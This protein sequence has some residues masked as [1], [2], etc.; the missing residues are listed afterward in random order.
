MG[1]PYTA[2]KRVEALIDGASGSDTR[3]LYTVRSPESRV[4]SPIPIPNRDFADSTSTSK[5]DG[6][7]G[8]V[9]RLYKA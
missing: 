1:C 2:Q 3:G 7:M 5:N 6:R 4:R 8:Q 9:F